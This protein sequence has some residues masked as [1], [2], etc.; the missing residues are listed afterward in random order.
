MN[1][2]N[3]NQSVGFPFQ[4]ETLSEMQKAY[5]IFNKLGDLAGN[6]AIISGC[7]VTGL[8]VSNGAVFIDGELLEFRGGIIQTTVIIVQES[9]SQEF[10]DNIARKVIFTRYVRFGVGLNSL[11]WSNFKR[12]MPTTTIL[13]AL[14]LKEDKTVV[15]LLISRIEALEAR[16]P[17]NIPLYGI[18]AFDRP[19]ADIPLGWAIWLPGQGRSLVGLDPNYVQGTDIINHNLKILNYQGGERE[20]KLTQAEIANYN[21]NRSVGYHNVSPGTALIWSSEPGPQYNTIINSGGGDKPH[22]NMAPHIIINYIQRI[23]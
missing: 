3:F 12:I 18:I 22:N 21:L 23:I 20:H 13:P 16:P 5:S 10:K 11:D 8:N 19:A 1:T 9:I 15:Q 14:Q 4:T 7:V 17:S 2:Q 6:F